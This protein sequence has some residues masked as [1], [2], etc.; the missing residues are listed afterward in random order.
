MS[1]CR[2][3]DTE[4]LLDMQLHNDGLGNGVALQDTS[5]NK[6]SRVKVIVL[7]CALP[8]RCVTCIDDRC[9]E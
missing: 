9:R 6:A 8:L 1:E 2:R 5:T 3:R 7:Y 4:G